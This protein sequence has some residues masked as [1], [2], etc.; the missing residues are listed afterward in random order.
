MAELADLDPLGK[1][2]KLTHLVLLDN[3][4]TR[5]EVSWEYPPC[6][7]KELPSNSSQHYRYYVIW[8]IPSV[9]F[10]DYQKV[11]DAE[12]AKAK[13]LFG[14]HEEPSAL[15]SKIMGIRSRT[16]DIPSTGPAAGEGRAAGE[17]PIRVKLTEKE[18][19]RVEKMIRE[20]KSLQEI[21]RIEKELN[22]GRIPGGALGDD[23]SDE[24]NKMR[25]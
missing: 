7:L 2:P 21:T 18:R 24:E 23:E 6:Q 16:F 4:V 5:K 8:R 15:A 12:R 17:K 1:L 3:P 13:E 11:K 20:A 25:M 14:T 10:L 9:R 22:E 19:K